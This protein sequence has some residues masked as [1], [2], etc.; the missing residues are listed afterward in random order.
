MGGK[1][2]ETKNL[3][4]KI[5]QRQANVVPW[6][7]INKARWQNDSLTGTPRVPWEPNLVS[8]FGA[9]YN[10]VPREAWCGVRRRFWVL[11]HRR[12][13]AFLPSNLKFV[14]TITVFFASWR[15][16]PSYYVIANLICIPP[17]SV[18][19]CHLYID[20]LLIMLTV[21]HKKHNV[22]GMRWIIWTGNT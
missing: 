18:I 13:G 4:Q 6:N 12:I 7:K 19:L 1:D 8:N 14:G 22:C 17:D 9:G 10:R 15:S 2:T 16:T 3:G 20:C 5:P 11:E 21:V